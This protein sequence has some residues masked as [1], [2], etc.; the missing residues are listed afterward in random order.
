M[1]HAEEGRELW[2]SLGRL[3]SRAESAR[4]RATR[5]GFTATLLSGAAVLISAPLFGVF[6]LGAYAPA[7]PALA[8][9]AAGFG[10]FTVER[11][12]MRKREASLR[13]ALAKKGLDASRPGRG[14]L[15]A[16]YD[17]QLI[18]LRSEYEY[19]LEKGAKRSARL[20]EESFGF[21]P[22]DPFETGP[23]NVM[24][25]TDGMHE[26]RARWERR[27]SM[28]RERGILPPGTGLREDMAYRVFPREMTVRAERAA[29]EAYLTISRGLIRSRYG[30][31]PEKS[32]ASEETKSRIRRDLAEYEELTGKPPA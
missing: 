25:D 17:A 30:R 24:T 10:M 21:T 23:L 13:D 14:G 4:R 27:L 2:Y 3:Y 31:N 26:L 19:L 28:R 12:S 29:R 6:W 8:G 20:F 7:I 1:R 5:L 11:A 16:Y 32:G 18:L 22:E 9:L 15:S